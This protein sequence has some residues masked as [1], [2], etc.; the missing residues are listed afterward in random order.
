M[1]R[2]FERKGVSYAAFIAYRRMLDM[3]I[4]HDKK[5]RVKLLRIDLVR[6][7][8]QWVD[9]LLKLVED[10]PAALEEMQE[11]IEARIKTLAHLLDIIIPSSHPCID[12]DTHPGNTRG[13]SG[14]V[15]GQ[16]GCWYRDGD[17]VD[18]PVVNGK[19]RGKV[20][21][22]HWVQGLEAINAHVA[23]V[24]GDL[25]Y[26]YWC[27][28]AFANMRGEAGKVE[29]TE[30]FPHGIQLDEDDSDTITSG[31]IYGNINLGL[32]SNGTVEKFDTIPQLKA[33]L[34]DMDDDTLSAWAHR[35]EGGATR[36]MHCH[37][38]ENVAVD[39]KFKRLPKNVSIGSVTVPS[40][41][42]G[43]QIDANM[44]ASR[45][46]DGFHCQRCDKVV[47]TPSP[48]RVDNRLLH[49]CANVV[50]QCEECNTYLQGTKH[51][52]ADAAVPT[53]GPGRGA[54]RR[55]PQARHRQ[56]RQ[57]QRGGG[58]EGPQGRISH[59]GAAMHRLDEARECVVQ[60][61]AADAHRPERGLLLHHRCR[62]RAEPAQ[63]SRRPLG[64]ACEGGQRRAHTPPSS[65]RQGERGEEEEG[66]HEGWE[67]EVIVDAQFRCC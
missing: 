9:A 14:G 63:G 21:M 46:A 39:L 67:Q 35:G 40:G 56:G 43:R 65:P 64:C 10:N 42:I 26:D 62:P 47:A 13:A 66:G 22:K 48:G 59:R 37:S 36:S 41:Q 58:Q 49:C 4:E 45:R 31:S 27:K 23:E 50:V 57:A 12:L 29:E 51:G 2:N 34:N 52:G 32:F 17:Y 1:G 25:P 30:L 7:E 20:L 44:C 3:L 38:T 53:A 54:A 16:N 8:K 15:P 61:R 33:R 28:A 5:S 24:V 6:S 19:I 18:G 11:A 60:D 55:G